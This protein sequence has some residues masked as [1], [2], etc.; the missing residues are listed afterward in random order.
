[1][2]NSHLSPAD[3]SLCPSVQPHG[4]RAGTESRRTEAP[5]GEAGFAPMYSYGQDRGTVAELGRGMLGPMLALPGHHSPALFICGGHRRKLMQAANS[6]TDVWDGAVKESNGR[7]KSGTRK[8]GPTEYG[9]SDSWTP[10]SSTSCFPGMSLSMSVVSRVTRFLLQQTTRISVTWGSG[11]LFMSWHTL[12][13]LL[14]SSLPRG[15]GVLLPTHDL[16]DHCS[17]RAQ[18]HGWLYRRTYRQAQQG[19]LDVTIRASLLPFF[20]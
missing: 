3:P 9:V 12:M 8:S 10:I 19:P 1:M 11:G 6:Q 13:W 17:R 20:F 4:E 14:G 5:Y 16:W 15:F 18:E 2:A 7:L